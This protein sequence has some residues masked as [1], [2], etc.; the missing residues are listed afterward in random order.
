M[1]KAKNSGRSNSRDSKYYL[2]KI[3]SL[4]KSNSNWFILSKKEEYECPGYAQANADGKLGY[5]EN[6]R[7]SHTHLVLAKDL[8]TCGTTAS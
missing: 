5:C 6:N 8:I 1:E 2:P 7:N 4:L 3:R